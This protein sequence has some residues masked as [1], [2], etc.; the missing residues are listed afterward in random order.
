[1]AY[2]LQGDLLEVCT[3]NVLCPC[4][5]GENPDGGICQS[6]LA[7][8]FD[9]GEID[10]VD[11][12]GVVAAGVVHIPGNVLDGS[13]RRRLYVS[14]SASDAQ[15]Q[16]VID[17]MQGRKGG[18]LAE[19]AKLIGEELEVRRAP[20]TF[21]LDEGAGRFRIEGVLDAEMAPYKGPTGETTTL[22]ESIFS[23]IPGSP[24]Y[25]AKAKHFRMKEPELGIDVDIEG[26]NAIQGKFRFEH[27]EAAAA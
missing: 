27:A 1:M 9:R 17:L 22:N 7:Y 20:I 11:V 3:C 13:W 16:A 12:G 2:S 19:L 21:E 18:P 6:T 5:I 8:R 26:R 10:G 23:T 4:W 15:A 14:D 24:A 25:V